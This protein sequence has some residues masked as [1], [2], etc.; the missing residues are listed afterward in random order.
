MI[1]S[2]T[3]E[4]AALADVIK[5]AEKVAPTR[6]SAFDKASGI[7]IEFDPSGTIPLAV[8]RATNLDIF[9]ME[10]VNVAEW[11]G[12][13][14]RWRLPSAL[15]ASIVGSLPIGTGKT[16]TMVSE[17]SNN[18]NIVVHV[19][20]GRTK[21]K[22]YPI[23]ISYYPPWGA[24]DPDDMFPAADLGGRIDQVEWAA[25]K[26]DPRLAGVYLDGTHAIAT[27]QYRLAV[28]PLS[29]PSLQEP[30]VVPSGILGQILRQT[31]E[32]QIGMSPEDRMLRV[33][34]DEY[35]QVKTVVYDVKYPNVTPVIQR[36]FDTAAK[37]DRD[38]LVEMIQRVN[39]FTQGDRAPS[40]RVYLGKEEV[41]V[42]VTN[43]EV[44][45]VGDAMEVPG[46][47]THAR[48]ELRFTPKNLLEALQKSPNNEVTLHYNAGD[49]K[50]MVKIDDG[51]GYRAWV[52]P[53][54]GTEN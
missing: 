38:K 10:W 4:T 30:I 8:V 20:S 49:G 2:V 17:Q 36:E 45:S 51:A 6:G 44:G 16:V 54:T 19:K 41:A 53:R 48:F 39:A 43:E 35:T 15:L 42:Y 47:A 24:F 3:F 12:E 5:K 14:A 1:S 33:M 34:P 18:N 31:G 23:D 13:P 25:G 46:E 52:M 32:V 22:F 9:M 21:A 29:I 40:L 28:V 27:D 11:S 7:V 37:V 26:Q 50:S